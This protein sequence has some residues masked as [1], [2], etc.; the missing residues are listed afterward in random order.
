MIE[1]VVVLVIVGITS[2]MSAGRIHELIIQQRIARA[3][4]AVQNSLEAAF[5]IAGRNRHPVR[6]AWDSVAKQL[7]VTDRAGTT[8]Y[9]HTGLGPDPYG[10]SANSVSFSRSPVEV[11]PNGLANDTLTITLTAPNLIKRIHMTRSGL[12]QIL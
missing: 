3:A 7:G 8:A 9:R 5:A 11:Y 10:L 1:I 4:T 12:V 6:I 2:A